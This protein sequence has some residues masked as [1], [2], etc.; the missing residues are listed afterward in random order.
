MVGRWRPNKPSTASPLASVSMNSLSLPPELAALAGAAPA[1]RTGRRAFDF[2]RFI[3]RSALTSRRLSG[4][5]QSISERVFEYRT[6]LRARSRPQMPPPYPPAQAGEGREG[7]PIL[8][9]LGEDP[10]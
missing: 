8:E 3:V 5:I 1:A 7:V 6:R 9:P 4:T 2:P 10:I